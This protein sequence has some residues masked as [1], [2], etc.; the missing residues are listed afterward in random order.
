M[1]DNP[2]G[3]GRDRLRRHFGFADRIL[4][5]R[6]RL[7]VAPS[8]QRWASRFPLTRPVARRKAEA[9]FDLCAGFVYSQVLF[10]C[11][12][13]RLLERVRDVPLPL[14]DLAEAT[15]LP[16]SRAELLIKSAVALDLLSY[17]SGDRVG[18]GMLGAA[19]LANPGISAMVRHHEL[20]YADLSDPVALLD[21]SKSGY[22]LNA[23]WSYAAKEKTAE[24]AAA[25]TQAYSALMTD[26]QSMLSEDI[27]DSYPFARHR[28]ILDLGGGEG[29]F[30][31]R[32]A[33]RVA[34]PELH[35]FDLPS[36]AARA[37]ERFAAAGLSER[38]RTTGGSF[39]SDPIPPGYDAITLV[40]VAH[41][42]D[43]GPMLDLF[44]KIRAALAPGGTLV[45]AEPMAD[46]KGAGRVADVYFAF[47]LLAMGSGRPRS[48]AE[49]AHLL[50]QAGF[51]SVKQMTTPRPML[52]SIVAATT[53]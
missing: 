5:L 49:L 38:A 41:D 45:I 28:R 53:A 46:V 51:S 35:L 34:G 21:G 4:S 26:S 27:I 39:F 15:T 9:A 24:L 19:I 2:P 6:D 20:L 30:L 16:L 10:A 8:F 25:E 3:F 29:E 11:V 37:A 13:L 22:R 17:R 36:V 40:R 50:S 33:R 31:L 47:Y 18:L 52:V 1:P 48:P 7:L 43:D 44:R 42:H 12:R 32:L 23:Y 14:V